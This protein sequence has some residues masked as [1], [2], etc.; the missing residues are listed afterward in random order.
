MVSLLSW[1]REQENMVNLDTWCRITLDSRLTTSLLSWPQSRCSLSLSR[2]QRCLESPISGES[3]KV[4][5]LPLQLTMPRSTFHQ[6]AHSNT[7]LPYTCD[8][9]A[10]PCRISTYFG[11]YLIHIHVFT[12]LHIANNM[13]Y[14]EQYAIQ[15]LWLI[16]FTISD[17][18][19]ASLQLSMLS[20]VCW[21][22]CISNIVLKPS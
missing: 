20:S 11:A 18:S 21:L 6:V 2:Q 5:P 12:E 8:N 22:C 16:F 15:S 10:R 4:W 9:T 1:Q 13:S 17:Q 7:I 3:D 14:S 19:D